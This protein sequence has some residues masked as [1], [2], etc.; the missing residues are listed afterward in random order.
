MLPLWQGSITFVP[1]CCDKRVLT[2]RL[3][4]SE[5]VMAAV[6]RSQAVSASD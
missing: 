1:F 3:S 4:I 5:R 6:I 2:G